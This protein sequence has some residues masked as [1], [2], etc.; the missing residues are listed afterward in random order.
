MK[1]RDILKAGL[2]AAVG[3]PLLGRESA[4][5]AAPTSADVLATGPTGGTGATGEG[6]R[7]GDDGPIYQARLAGALRLRDAVTLEACPPT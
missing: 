3:F 5:A 2:G 6:L 1:R 7:L 4:Q